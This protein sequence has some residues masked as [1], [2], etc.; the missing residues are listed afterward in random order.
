[1]SGVK[2]GVREALACLDEF[3]ARWGDSPAWPETEDALRATVWIDRAEAG[4]LDRRAML[5]RL[6]EHTLSRLFVE[7]EAGD[8][9]SADAL[10][11][12]LAQVLGELG[13]GGEARETAVAALCDALGR[14]LRRRRLAT[15]LNG[16]EAHQGL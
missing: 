6:A 15:G 2:P 16:G 3:R 5:R 12:L 11:R 4:R 9:E 8:G 13:G 7:V 14:A 1:M 10:L